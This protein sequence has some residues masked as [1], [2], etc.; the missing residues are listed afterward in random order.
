MAANAAIFVSWLFRCGKIWRACHGVTAI[1]NPDK[2]GLTVTPETHTHEK[3]S[4][5]THRQLYDPAR[6]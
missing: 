1:V 6:A 4:H 5:V 2:Q 3:H